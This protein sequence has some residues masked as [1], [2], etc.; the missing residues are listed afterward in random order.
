VAPAA[1]LPLRADRPV[2][3]VAGDLLA[4]LDERLSRACA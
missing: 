1:H 2:D 4:L 3:A